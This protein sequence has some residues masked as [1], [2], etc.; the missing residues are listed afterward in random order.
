MSGT[1]VRLPRRNLSFH[2]TVSPENAPSS[3]IAPARPFLQSGTNRVG[4]S[5]IR[6]LSFWKLYPR[7]AGH[8][9]PVDP[10][11]DGPF[12]SAFELFT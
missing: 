3:A 1:V 12:V 2:Y 7:C 8:G 11:E 6:L 4:G 10:A 9:E 5:R